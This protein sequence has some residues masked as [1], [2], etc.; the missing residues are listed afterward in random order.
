[1]D[2]ISYEMEDTTMVVHLENTPERVRER[3]KYR[4]ELGGRDTRSIT[5]CI[6]CS[7]GLWE[8]WVLHLQKSIMT[9]QMKSL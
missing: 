5:C 4:K 6:S 1:M 3:R 2:C 7:G 8:A 9:I